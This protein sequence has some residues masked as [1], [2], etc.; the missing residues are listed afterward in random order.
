MLLYLVMTDLPHCG[1]LIVVCIRRSS[2]EANR[3]GQ[4]RRASDRKASHLQGNRLETGYT[5][6]AQLPLLLAL[7]IITCTDSNAHQCTNAQ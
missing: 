5:G 4:A 6:I 1:W 3:R 2:R 7:K